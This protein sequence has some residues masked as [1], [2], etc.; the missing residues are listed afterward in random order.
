MVQKVIDVVGV[1]PVS[2]A[3][4]AQNAVSEAAKTVREMRWARVGEMEME[5]EGSKVKSYRATVRIYFN[6]ER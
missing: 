2:F 5:L 1:S 3:K 4:A 6:I